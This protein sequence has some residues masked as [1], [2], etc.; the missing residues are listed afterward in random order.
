MK[1]VNHV[2]PVLSGWEAENRSA[3]ASMAVIAALAIKLRI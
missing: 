3:L 1:S 2:K